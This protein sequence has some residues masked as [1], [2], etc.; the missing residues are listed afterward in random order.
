MSAP[1]IVF[2]RRAGALAQVADLAFIDGWIELPSLTRP[3]SFDE[4]GP[5]NAFDLLARYRSAGE[6]FLDGARGEFAAAVFDARTQIAIAARDGM[7]RRYL[8]YF[9]DAERFAASSSEAELVA[10]QGLSATLHSLRLAEF[11]SCVEPSGRASFFEAISALLPGEVLFVRAEDVG[12]HWLARPKLAERTRL[13]SW[14]EYVEGFAELLRRAVERSLKGVDK[15]AVWLSGGLDSSP[16]AAFAAQKLGAAAIDALCWR[17]DDP[18]GDESSF[19]GEVA[20]RLGLRLFWVDCHD[21][22]PY[23]DLS[24]WPV[25]P[26]TPEQTAYRHFHQ[27]SYATAAGLGH[28]FV[29]NG[30]GGDMLYGH[31]DRW[32]WSL[33][34]AEGMGKAIDRLRTVA[35]R[36]GWVRTIRRELAGP[37]LRGA[38][39]SREFVPEWLLPA[40]RARLELRPSWPEDLDMASRRQQAR[41]LLS[42]SDAA[43][44]S[45]EAWYAASFGIEPRTPL[46]DL[47]LVQFMLSVPDHL[48]RQGT[49]TR[50]ILRSSMLES[51]PPAVV[52][53]TGKAG[54]GSVL[55]RGLEPQNLPWAPALLL[56][57][58][59]LWREHVEEAAVRRWL[60]GDLSGSSDALGL[61]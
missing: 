33:L 24:N 55:L 51:L 30:L 61:L 49:E 8:S 6:S 22:T 38:G 31:G 40:S 47:D 26:S 46:R 56:D 35:R 28:K 23:S 60:T 18:E 3:G 17:I 25:H 37:L 11:Y 48:L 42:L 59:A 5:A 15:A 12:R 16:I 2:E 13:G 43:W 4:F 44:I 29:L 34:A 36:D 45:Q 32:F 20:N 21:A 53:R 1:L 27:R 58:E 19:A 14:E 39:R 10:A 7:G 57:P 41:R 54:F 52:H 9:L 50:P